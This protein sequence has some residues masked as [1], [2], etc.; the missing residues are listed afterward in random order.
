MIEFDCFSSQCNGLNVKY[1]V[2]PSIPPSR[3]IRDKTEAEGHRKYHE[4]LQCL[5]GGGKCEMCFLFIKS[6][7][8]KDYSERERRLQR[9]RTGAESSQVMMT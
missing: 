3:M 4:N 9:E 1:F 2:A 7:L 5:P 6:S 8:G